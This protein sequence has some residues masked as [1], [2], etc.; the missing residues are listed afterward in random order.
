MAEDQQSPTIEELYQRAALNYSDISEH[1]PTLFR[2][3]RMVNH[4]TEFGTRWGVSTAAFL[5]A[6]PRR[7]VAYDI[8]RFPEVDVLVAAAEQ[9]GLDFEFRLESVLETTIEPTELLF[10]D[11]LH[12]YDQLL[13]ELERHAESVSTFIAMHDTSTYG[14]V[15]EVPGTVGLWPAIQ[16]YFE[17][18]PQWK[19]IDRWMNNNG[20]TLY[21][22]VSPPR[23]VARSPEG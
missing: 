4:I 5:R 19:L 3:G 15:G 1:I 8:A 10:I 7:F 22:R 13:A 21:M 17:P 11:T 23:F 14:D 16:E 12:T 18:R 20:L 2:L 9:A 6:A